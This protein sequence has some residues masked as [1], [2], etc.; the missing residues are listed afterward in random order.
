LGSAVHGEKGLSRCR[1]VYLVCL[2]LDKTEQKDQINE[3]Q[4]T[5]DEFL[6]RKDYGI[7]SSFTSLDSLEGGLAG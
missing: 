4:N 5:I 6:D 2:V 7:W 1:P 3:Q